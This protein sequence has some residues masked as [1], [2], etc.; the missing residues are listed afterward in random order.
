M[1]FGGGVSGP[2][3]QKWPAGGSQL[4][5]GHGFGGVWGLRPQGWPAG[6]FAAEEPEYR[7]S[8]FE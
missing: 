2:G 8:R 1:P 4:N 3:P 7:R 6:G 5:C